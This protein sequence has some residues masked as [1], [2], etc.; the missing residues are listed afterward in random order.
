MKV[1]YFTI[2]EITVTY[3]DNVKPSERFRVEKSAD[4]AKIL[5]VAFKDCMQHH[6]QVYVLY[7]NKG[8]RVLGI[9]NVAKGGIDGAFVD[10]RVILQT[11]LKVSASCLILSHN[12]PSGSSTPSKYDKDL[13]EKIKL[14]CQVVGL[15]LLDHV[16][17]TEE[18]YSSF[19]D[20]G[21]L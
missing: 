1:D 7:M 18:T 19:A 14:G 17:M 4:I 9:S 3:K 5:E 10:I 8:H 12:H 16:I 11:A 20:E 13:T 21:L 6:E 2:P 15:T